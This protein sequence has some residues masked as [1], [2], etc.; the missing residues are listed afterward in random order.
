MPSS[1]L[2]DDATLLMSTNER[3][4]GGGGGGGECIIDEEWYIELSKFNVCIDTTKHN[5]LDGEG[6][7]YHYFLKMVKFMMMDIQLIIVCSVL[8]R[9][10]AWV[11]LC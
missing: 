9:L 10:C 7:A 5:V 11:V 6:Q 1:T 4:G 2:C 8:V 3:R